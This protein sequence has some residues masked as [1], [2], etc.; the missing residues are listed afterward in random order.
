MQIIEKLK[1]F[2]EESISGKIEL[3]IHT[4][5]VEVNEIKQEIDGISR[6]MFTKFATSTK[7]PKVKSSSIRAYLNSLE[8]RS[9]QLQESI[10]QAL[11]KLDE[12]DRDIDSGNI[13]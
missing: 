10:Q 5:Q 7:I 1:Q 2:K 12:I 3:N 8:K 6:L 13:D 11:E 4:S 9:H